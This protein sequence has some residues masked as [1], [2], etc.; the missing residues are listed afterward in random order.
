MFWWGG[1]AEVSFPVIRHILVHL[2]QSWGP[3]GPNK[4]KKT[5]KQF[6]WFLNPPPLN[7]ALF[8]VYYFV[9]SFLLCF[10]GPTNFVCSFKTELVFNWDWTSVVYFSFLLKHKAANNLLQCSNI[11]IEAPFLLRSQKSAKVS[12]VLSIKKGRDKCKTAVSN[13]GEKPGWKN[14]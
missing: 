5:K 2:C 1:S 4:N 6:N 14:L 7:L 13:M 9:T 8:S 3:L 12:G 10:A 11:E